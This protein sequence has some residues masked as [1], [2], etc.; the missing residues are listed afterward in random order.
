MSLC[1]EAMIVTSG[2]G[3]LLVLYVLATLQFEAD[4]E[5]IFRKGWVSREGRVDA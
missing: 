3:S 5:D 4:M 1:L 2:D